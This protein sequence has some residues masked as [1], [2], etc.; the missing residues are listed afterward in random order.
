MLCSC[1]HGNRV[2]FSVPLLGQ[3]ISILSV[4]LSHFLVFILLCVPVPLC[5]ALENVIYARICEKLSVNKT[6]REEENESVCVCVF[7]VV[8]K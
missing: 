4:S 8:E 3:I 5:C 6:K 7:Y 2:Q 1:V